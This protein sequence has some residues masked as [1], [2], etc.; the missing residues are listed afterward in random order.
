MINFYFCIFIQ[1]YLFK[2]YYSIIFKFVIIFEKLF[3][4]QIIKFFFFWN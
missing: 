4:K 1:I 2:F 3:F